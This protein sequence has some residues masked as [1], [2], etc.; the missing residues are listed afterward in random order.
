MQEAVF[1]QE[2]VQ[3][4]LF[5]PA[6]LGPADAQWLKLMI[7]VVLSVAMSGATSLLVSTTTLELAAAVGLSLGCLAT[8]SAFEMLCALRSQL[9]TLSS[10]LGCFVV[11]CG[12][13]G[14]VASRLLRGRGAACGSALLPV[15]DDGV[16]QFMR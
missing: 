3:G 7:A 2:F 9:V 11:G 8:M 1:R 13:G 16:R 14:V 12:V 15:R 10:G 4:L 6:A 5:G